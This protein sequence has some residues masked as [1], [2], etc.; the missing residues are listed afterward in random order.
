MRGPVRLN[1]QR[2]TAH[3]QFTPLEGAVILL[4]ALK[5]PALDSGAAA[6]AAKITLSFFFRFWCKSYVRAPTL[7]QEANYRICLGY[8]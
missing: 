2:S 6:G 7:F 1:E 8:N 5:A 4:Q 3:S